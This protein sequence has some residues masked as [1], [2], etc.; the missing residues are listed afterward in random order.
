[1]A[2]YLCNC[3]T[4]AFYEEKQLFLYLGFEP[5]YLELI[6]SKTNFKREEDSNKTFNQ[7]D[8]PTGCIA[9]PRAIS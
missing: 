4:T 1:V 8:T 7:I 2:E 3:S 9:S 5:V 6:S